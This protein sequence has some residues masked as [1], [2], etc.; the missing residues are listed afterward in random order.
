MCIYIY[1]NI[2]YIINVYVS[3][4]SNQCLKD[5]THVLHNCTQGSYTVLAHQSLNATHAMDDTLEA[6][7]CVALGYDTVP[8]L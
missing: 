1:N 8:W 3:T 7:I 5:G 2:V 4:T 6:I